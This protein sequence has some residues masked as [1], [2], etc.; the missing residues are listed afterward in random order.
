V[1]RLILLEYVLLGAFGALVGVAIGALAAVGITAM[2]I[3]MPP[4]PGSDVSY[5][6]VVPLIPAVLLQAFIVGWLACVIASLLP[7][8]RAAGLPIV[9]AL[10]AN[11]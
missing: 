6:A 8:R 10:R 11:I 2:E 7:G 5:N 4:Q 1:F 3:P 9:E